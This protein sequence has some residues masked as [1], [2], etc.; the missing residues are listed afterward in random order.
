[1]QLNYMAVPGAP[2][3]YDVRIRRIER[4]VA[5]EYNIPVEDLHRQNKGL[6]YSIPRGVAMYLIRQVKKPGGKPVSVVEIS[7]RYNM[8][9]TSVLYQ[10]SRVKNDIKYTPGY[11]ERLQKLKGLI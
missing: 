6:K 4:A 8:H 2:T 7:A 1:M 9:H 3:P 5:E 10:L 11:A